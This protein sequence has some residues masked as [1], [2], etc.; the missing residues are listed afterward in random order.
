V[1]ETPKSGGP[2]R[3]YLDYVRWRLKGR[4]V[5]RA[6]SPTVDQW[7]EVFSSVLPDGQPILGSID[8]VILSPDGREAVTATLQSLIGQVDPHWRAMVVEAGDLLADEVVESPVMDGRVVVLDGSD[9]ASINAAV[10]RS[11]ADLVGL[12]AAGTTLSSVATSWIRSLPQGTEVVFADHIATDGQAVFKPAWSPSLA[13][14]PGFVGPVL[15]V[16]PSTLA[17]VGGIGDGIDDLAARLAASAVVTVHIPNLLATAPPRWTPRLTDADPVEQASTP[18]AI[19]RAA[20][21]KV[22]IPT[23]D[24]VELLRTAV[25]GVLG[26]TSRADVSLVIVDN[27]SIEVATASYL[28]EINRDARVTVERVDEPFNFS[29][30]CNI[31]AATGPRADVILF[32]NN[33]IVATE[34]GWLDRL[35]DPIG[36]YGIAAVGPILLFCDGRIQH[37][38]VVVGRDQFGV[39]PSGD[40]QPLAAHLAHGL[41]PVE[42]DATVFGTTRDVTALTAACLAIDAGVFLAVGGFDEQLAIDFQDVDLCLRVGAMGKRLLLEAGVRL[43]HHESASRGTIGASAPATLQLMTQRWGRQLAPGDPAFSPHLNLD[44]TVAHVRGLPSEEVSR[45][46]GPR[47]SAAG[48]W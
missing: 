11:E 16:E 23:R 39:E 20:S 37:A 4:P 18:A 40:Y 45:R 34:A 22:V 30:L 5:E 3:R 29:R 28:T 44:L 27:G 32:M 14:R 46:L 26:E 35:V 12:V 38:G 33:D 42:L 10:N 8:Y 19:E 1:S 31:G 9:E 6:V 43:V 48:A 7:R 2:V 21:V 47:S 25:D 17:A 13:A 15:L 41:P 36:T 24:R